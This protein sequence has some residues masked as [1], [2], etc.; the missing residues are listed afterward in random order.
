MKKILALT[1][2][3]FC[4]SIHCQ[5]KAGLVLQKNG[6][7][8][9]YILFAPLHSKITYLIDK[10]GK[11]VHS[12]H[13]NYPPGQSA[14]LLPGGDLLRCANDSNKTFKG[15]GRIERF[16][17]DDKLEWS[18]TISSTTECQH[19]DICPLPNGNILVL[20]WEKKS[21]EEA[22]QGGRK[23]A[24]VN[25]WIWSEKIVELKPLG[26]NS[27][28]IVWE[29]H[30]W[31][32][33]VQNYDS[34]KSNY[35]DPD[36]NRQLIHF[37]Y[38]T[39]PDADWLHFNSIAYNNKLDQILVSNRNLSEIFILDHSTSTQQAATHTGG[40]HNKGGD[41][42][43]RYGNPAVY[44]S[45]AFR[46]QVFFGQ[47]N[48]HWIDPTL[49]DGGKILLFNNGMGRRQKIYSSV[50]IISPPVD[51]AG[52]YGAI[53]NTIYKQVYSEEQ[54][55]DLGGV[56]FSPNV[57]GVQRLSNGNTLV[58]S[59]AT[60]QFCEL[61]DKNN[62]VWL[63][64]NPVTIRGIMRRG[65]I[66][67]NNQVFRCAFYEPTYSAF[68]RK[69]LKPGLPIEEITEGYSCFGGPEEK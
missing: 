69:K 16:N 62:S 54:N 8:Q 39:T 13:S 22:L 56:F 26:K 3:F 53:E 10:C 38:T 7:Q 17:W 68:K 61:D 18:Y 67:T 41:L 65:N 32:H 23:P 55:E 34:L 66:A 52:N 37:N 51:T 47:H 30:A 31:D 35:G 44:K 33:L 36:K 43:Y 6:S 27:A 5:N 24:L 1:F 4:Y 9:G 57:S 63:Y 59:G 49:K 42:L 58:C 12:W 28:E 50:D 60:G 64:I 29:W 46:D 15:G 21:K 2:L 25:D 19:H 20:V 14:Y 48:A 45:E 11:Q 40:K